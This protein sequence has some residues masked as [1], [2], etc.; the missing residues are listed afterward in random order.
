MCASCPRENHAALNTRQVKGL[1]HDRNLAF[2]NQGISNLSR[3]P[4][5]LLGGVLYLLL[6][7]R[8]IERKPRSMT[9]K[10]KAAHENG[11]RLLNQQSGSIFTYAFIVTTPELP[12][13]CHECCGTA[14]HVEY[15]KGDPLYRRYVCT[16]C[17]DKL[18]WKSYR[19]FLKRKG[20]TPNV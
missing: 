14:E 20:A 16:P 2:H 12:V 18:I 6:H 3:R 7:S 15:M 1:N 19:R 10:E 11:I 4:N 5:R 17:R 9:P 13:L 8:G